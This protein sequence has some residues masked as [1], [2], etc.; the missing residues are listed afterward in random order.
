MHPINERLNI[1]TNSKYLKGTMSQWE[2]EINLK[3]GLKVPFLLRV[4]IHNSYAL[5]IYIKCI[6]ILIYKLFT[7]FLLEFYLYFTLGVLGF[8]GAM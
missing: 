3:L 1:Q 2:V 4:Y 5:L 8:W 7:H 6:C